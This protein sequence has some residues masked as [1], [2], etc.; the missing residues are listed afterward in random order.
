VTW[1]PPTTQARIRAMVAERPDWCISRQRV[2]GI[3][4][5]AFYCLSCG[6]VLLTPETVD[7]VRAIV[8]REG[9]DAW[10]K[11]EAADLLPAGASCPKCRRGEFRKETDIFDVWF[12]SGSSHVAVLL[13]RPELAWPA[14]LYLEGHDQHRGWFQASL[15]T[16][17]VARGAAPYRSVLTTGFFLDATGQK[18]SKS[19][20]NIIDPQE[21][22][23]RYGAD[24]LRLWVSYVDFKADMPM[25]E[26]IFNQVIEAYRRIRNTARFLLANLYD[27]EPARDAVEPA[28]MLEVDRWAMHH[29]QQVVERV[30]RA[31]ETFEFHRV[32]HTLNTFCAVDLSAF[33]LDMLKDRLYTSPAASRQRRSAQTALYQIVEVLARLLA[34]ILAHTAEEIW[35]AVPGREGRAASV[36]LADWPEPDAQWVDGALGERWQG[37]L[38][39]RGEIALALEA[40]RQ[41]KVV[42]QPLQAAVA[43]FAAP[44]E[45]E[46]LASLG[47]QLASVLI[48]SQAGLAEPGSE[49][50]AEGWRSEAVPGLA[51]VVE[52]A[53]GGKCQRCWQYQPSVGEDA[54]H[55]GLCARCTAAL[56]ER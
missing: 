15:W 28:Q 55:P 14:D 7:A 52:R 56:R 12:D 16:A 53:S 40:A 2:W 38:A 47:D 31:Y 48:V 41:A 21:I 25:S 9:S 32:Y 43:I 23:G 33:Y 13:A 49:P 4:I 19:L 20:G 3:P 26:D 10:F 46:M 8:E 50:P 6:E 51:A 29:L 27:F 45:R 5:P 18:M 30:T 39:L 22:A 42:S 37:I 54:G 1:I 17:I 36:Q 24:I 11:R 35:Q 44:P 34:P